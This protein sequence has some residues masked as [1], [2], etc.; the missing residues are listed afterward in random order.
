MAI[1][2]ATMRSWVS[3][4][5]RRSGLSVMSLLDSSG[6]RF[7]LDPMEHRSNA[8]ISVVIVG[9]GLGGL[10]LARILHL[11]GVACMIYEADVS[12]D[13]RPQ[14]GLLDI[15]EADGQAALAAAGL[16]EAFRKITLPGGEATRLLNA[17]GGVLFE[18]SDDGG[19]GRPEVPRGE[20][21][22][23][24]IESLPEG[25]IRWGSKL[26]SVS[27][28]A[29]GRHLL[30]F[31]D[32]SV[33]ASGFVVGA[34]GAWSRVRPL[35]TDATPVYV[36]VSFVETWLHDVDTRHPATAAAAGQ[37]SLF[38]LAPGQ[39]VFAHREPGGVLHAYVALSRPLDWFTAVDLNDTAAVRAHIA[40]EFTGWAS[41]LTALITD[42]ETS[43]VLRPLYALPTG[44]TWPRKPGVTLIGDAAHL[45]PP[46]GE[47]ANLAL[48]DGA[49]LAAAIAA[50]PSDAEAALS[51]YEAAL[52]PRAE[53]AAV[54]AHRMLALCLDHRAPAGLVE[55]FTGVTA[56]RA[57]APDRPT[58]PPQPEDAD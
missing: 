45:A 6:A 31:A 15:H 2:A 9:A 30:R 13:A 4:V 42:G 3:G 20:L 58:H 8:V 33:V 32:G 54:E 26:A 10:V 12:A 38:A 55:F 14:G 40:A 50:H 43:P 52:F 48:Q 1:A 56:G 22:R 29:D 16:T 27:L 57:G 11:H 19:G 23:L 18:E 41:A 36:G 46:A 21:R 49:E 5:L 47:G 25:M 7:Q 53:A 51:S 28:L 37:G 44:L 34:D 39:G 17:H 35:V 24:L